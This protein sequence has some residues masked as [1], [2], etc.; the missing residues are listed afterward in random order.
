LRVPDRRSSAIEKL[1]ALPENTRFRNEFLGDIYLIS[2]KNDQALAHYLAEGNTFPDAR[3]SQRSALLELWRNQDF[4]QLNSLLSR[5]GFRGCLRAGELMPILTDSR[6]FPG[7]LRATFQQSL[8]QFQFPEIFP[9]LFTALIWSLIFFSF[10]SVT[11]RTVTL[12]VT[13][14][15]LGVISACLTLFTLMIQERIQGFTFDPTDS[16][17]SQIIYFVAGVGLREEG[18]KLLCFVPMAIWILPRKNDL[19]GFILAGMVGLGFASEENFSYFQNAFDHTVVWSRFL[20]A[21]ALHFSLTG[22]S[23]YFF[24]RMLVGKGRGWENFLTNF[25]IAVTAHGLYDALISMPALESYSV[26]GLIA[27]ALIAYRYFDLLRDHLDIDGLHLRLSPL[28]VFVLGSAVLLCSTLIFSAG[29]T[30]FGQAFGTFAMSVGGM[31]PLAFA[32]ISRFR[33]I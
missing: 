21:N 10:S 5:P 22:V 33:D 4:A 7:L 11:G 16:A 28:G 17:L 29:L 9:P 31:I 8:D 14:F 18:M 6:N 1:T 19:E 3:Y 2:K 23:G 13:A 26:L 27:L 15:L 25:L 30:S 20:T 24:F 12:S 32:F